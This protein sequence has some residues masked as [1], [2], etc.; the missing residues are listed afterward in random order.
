VVLVDALGALHQR[1][2]CGV[3]LLRDVGDEVMHVLDENDVVVERALV[4]V[5]A[6]DA[7]HLGHRLQ[8]LEHRAAQLL[9]VAIDGGADVECLRVAKLALDALDEDLRSA[10]AS[11][12]TSK[13]H[14]DAPER[15]G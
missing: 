1:R 4:L 13:R 10:S 14:S 2:E 15:R 3:R 8:H 12:R 5:E 6:G 7:V 9:V 11:T